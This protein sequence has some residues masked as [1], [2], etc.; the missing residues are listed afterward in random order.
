MNDDIEL[1]SIN[2]FARRFLSPEKITLPKAIHD[3]LQN[4]VF[5]PTSGTRLAMKNI[6][7]RLDRICSVM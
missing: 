7:V 5:E 1:I 4:K 3:A 2:E 6:S